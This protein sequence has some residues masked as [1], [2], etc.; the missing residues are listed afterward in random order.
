[1]FK[2]N[3]QLSLSKHVQKG[4]KIKHVFFEWPLYQNMLKKH[5]RKWAL[6][7]CFYWS[8]LQLTLLYPFKYLLDQQRQIFL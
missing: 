3:V 4:P 6:E 1:M 5:V 2:K 8:Q 7:N